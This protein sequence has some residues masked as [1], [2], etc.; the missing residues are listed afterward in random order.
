VRLFDTPGADVAYDR[1]LT[2]TPEDR[3]HPSECNCEKC[4]EWHID[5]GMVIENA[6]DWGIDFQ[7]CVDE[8]DLMVEKK[9]ACRTHPKSYFEPATKT[10]PAHCE[11]C[12]P[13]YFK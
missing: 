11:G 1:W 12:E 13:E 5:E 2:T 6:V 3:A 8:F 4:H 10:E 7:C 9:Q